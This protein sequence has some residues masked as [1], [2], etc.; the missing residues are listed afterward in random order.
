MFLSRVELP[1]EAVRNPYNMHRR[2][3]RLFPGC[4][5][6]AR[7]SDDEERQGFLFRVEDAQT[8]RPARLLVQSRLV[9]VHAD[10]ALILGMREF[11][12]RPSRGQRLA[13]LLTANP[14]KM[15]VDAQHRQDAASKRLK[16]CRVPFV[17][18]ED[19]RL[20]LLRKLDGIATV[21]SPCC[22]AETPAIFP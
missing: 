22:T 15:I 1:W 18:E 6:E 4:P 13:F 7:A 8:G 14:V 20:W 16:R 17:K 11:H 19:Q 5:R 9:P 2:L 12:P 21:D 3:W 10:G